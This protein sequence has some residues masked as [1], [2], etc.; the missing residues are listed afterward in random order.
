MFDNKSTMESNNNISNDGIFALLTFNF[1]DEIESEVIFKV[2]TKFNWNCELVVLKVGRDNKLISPFPVNDCRNHL[3]KIRNQ[4]SSGNKTKME[5]D[6]DMVVESEEIQNNVADSKNVNA[7]EHGFSNIDI[8][9]KQGLDNQ[10]FSYAGAIKKTNRISNNLSDVVDSPRSSERIP[11]HTRFHDREQLQKVANEVLKGLKVM[12]IMRG[13]P[14][15]GKSHL[16]KEIVD[17]TTRDEYYNHIFTTDDF[18]YDRSGNYNFNASQL[19]EA[20]ESNKKRVDH[21]AQSGWSPIIVDNTNIRVWEMSNYFEIAVRCGYLIHIVEPNTAWSRSAGKLAMKNSHGVPK[22]AIERMLMNYEPTTVQSVMESFGLNYSMPMPQYRQFPPTPIKVTSKQDDVT[23]QR[24]LSKPQRSSKSLPK[25]NNFE[26][27]SQI[28]DVV[29]Y[30]SVEEA[31]QNVNKTSDWGTFDKEQ[32]D[33]WN[34]NTTELPQLLPLLPQPKQQRIAKKVSDVKTSAVTKDEVHSNLFAILKENTETIEN[35]SSTDE[36]P[37]EI[38]NKHRKNCRNENGSFAQIRQIY[39]T[40]ALEILW[41][42]FEKCEGDGDW[43]MDILL[44]EETRIG[45]Y[46]DGAK[47]NFDCDCD[48]VQVPA[49]IEEIPIM[50][51]ALPYQ[52]PRRDRSTVNTEEQLAAKRMIEGS[53]QISDEHYSNH[54]RK[55]R[56]LRRGV[57]SPVSVAQSAS[58]DEEGACAIDEIEPNEEELLEINLGMDLV[59]QLDSVFGVEVYQREAIADMKTAVFMP[60][61][62]A[63]QLYALWMESMYNQMEE[64][65]KKSIK[66]D[67]EFAR[68]L[69][70]QQNYPGLYK[71]AKPPSNLKDI[72]EMEYAW[73]AYKTEMDEW[74]LKTPQD[75]ALQMSHDK[76]CDIFPNIDRETLIEVLAA[77]NNKFTE[78]VDVLKDTLGKPED[79]LLNEGQ[80]LFEEVRAEVEMTVS[81]RNDLW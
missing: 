71:H 68:Q 30:E 36:E 50:N 76:L 64:Q 62:L 15:C 77:H 1:G 24:H 27:S 11:S 16:A 41:D 6:I 63:Q 52:R 19:G 47:N 13:P 78:T 72:M 67:A 31:F 69:Q 57:V 2:C 22:E 9:G 56:N 81:T 55:I 5:T 60:K 49:S 40:V 59:C 10:P 48:Y 73:A 66:E 26:M 74:K 12:V 70:S 61:S 4:K 3:T 75:L 37:K 43:T 17:A 32:T 29:Q 53:F 34:A 45:N 8:E 54:T 42:L 65:R 28:P 80:E 79:K 14:G 18:F 58:N 20:H 33:F 51:N 25:R 23:N 44:K 35:K 46:T 7:L 38:L 39:P 21:Y